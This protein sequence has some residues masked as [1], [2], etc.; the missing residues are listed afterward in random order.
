MSILVHQKELQ[1]RAH[2][3]MT[4]IIPSTGRWE[5][6]SNSLSRT[7]HTLVTGNSVTTTC[8]IPKRGNFKRAWSENHQTHAALTLPRHPQ[9][10]LLP[11]AAQNQAASHHN[12]SELLST[13]SNSQVHGTV[14]TAL[15]STLLSHRPATRPTTTPPCPRYSEPRNTPHYPI[16]APASPRHKTNRKK[17]N[18]SADEPPTT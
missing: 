6:N 13:T 10:A 18:A 14:P 12:P 11:S 2:I 3:P 9:W 17:R 1:S 15:T 16:P 8:A 5:G 4:S 7:L